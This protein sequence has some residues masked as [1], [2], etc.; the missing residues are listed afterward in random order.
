MRQMMRKNSLCV[1]EMLLC[2][3]FVSFGRRRRRAGEMQWNALSSSPFKTRI[4]GVQQT[5]NYTRIS[6]LSLSLSLS[7][8]SFFSP[9]SCSRGMHSLLFS[10]A[11]SR[12]RGGEV[13][14]EEFPFSRPCIQRKERRRN[15]CRCF[16]IGILFSL[17]NLLPLSLS[18]P[19]AVHRMCS[20]LC[21]MCICCEL[22]ECLRTRRREEEEE[23]EERCRRREREKREERERPT[24][25]LYLHYSHSTH[26]LTLCVRV[27][28]RRRER[29]SFLS[30]FL[31]HRFGS[32]TALSCQ[33]AQQH[34]ESE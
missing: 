7:L 15:N 3:K 27:F 12:S 20:L 2:C 32:T 1:C 6:R 8:S 14:E 22:C 5:T 28:V 26:T 33:Q 11:K 24:P 21:S 29:E 30:K 16:C 31:P 17:L 34:T 18:L 25:L 10:R 9:K 19:V 13:R 4:S 23:G